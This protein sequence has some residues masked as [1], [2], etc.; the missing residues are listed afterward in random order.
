MCDGRLH[1]G[2][3]H[4]K[5]AMHFADDVGFEGSVQENQITGDGV[6][7]YPRCQYH[8]AF[9]QGCAEGEGA[10]TLGEE[11]RYEGALNAGDR[12]SHS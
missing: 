11:A 7:K 9:R 2:F 5:M 12:A 6:V 10:L 1:H 8:G 3:L 4:G